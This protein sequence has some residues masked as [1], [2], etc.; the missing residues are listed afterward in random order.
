MGL[1]IQKNGDVRLN[2]TTANVH[3]T[4]GAGAP[5]ALLKFKEEEAGMY[6][7]L[8]L[9]TPKTGDYGFSS[10]VDFLDYMVKTFG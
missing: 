5:E 4:A 10:P 1:E 6:P 2:T 9:S 8:H 7:G 3:K